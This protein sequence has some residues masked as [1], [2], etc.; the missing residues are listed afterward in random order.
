MPKRRKPVVEPTTMR[1]GLDPEA[2]AT[3]RAE[4]ES[5]EG[6]ALYQEIK[7]MEARAVSSPDAEATLDDP[8]PLPDDALH[9]AAGATTGNAPVPASADEDDDDDDG[10]D[11]DDE[12]S[13][14]DPAYVTDP[15]R[16]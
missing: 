1:I 11:N 8:T 5:P 14:V 15:V 6:E 12:L 16:L 10:W 9:L 7:R 3:A 2:E 13:G 4:A